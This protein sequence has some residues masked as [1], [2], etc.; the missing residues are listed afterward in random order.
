MQD[1]SAIYSC[2]SWPAILALTPGKELVQQFGADTFPV[3][4]SHGLLM[5]ANIFA[6]TSTWFPIVLYSIYLRVYLSGVLD[7][8]F[9]KQPQTETSSMM[10]LN[11]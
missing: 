4:I 3:Y 11:P 7:S 8:A 6:P 5:P 9:G 2:F 1:S 10:F